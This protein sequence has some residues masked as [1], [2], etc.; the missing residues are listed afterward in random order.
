MARGGPIP[1][2]LA[3]AILAALAACTMGP[4][5]SRPDAP[6]SAGYKEMAGWKPAEPRD[7]ASGGPWWSIFDDPVLDE[8][9]R[10]IDV[11]NQTLKASEAAFRLASA[12]VREGE[13]G[14]Y[15]TVTGSGSAQR[16]GSPGVR[17]SAGGSG[18]IVANQFGATANA[19]WVPDI[20]GKIRRTVESDVA[21]AQ[22]SAADLA[23]ARLSAQATLAS[24]YFQLRISD[25]L[26]RVLDATIEAYQRSL[27]IARNQYTAG[28]AAQ[29]DLIT[30]RTQLEGAQAEEINLGVQRAALEHAIAVLTGQPPSD[31]TLAPAPLAAA[32]PVMPPGLPSS[33]LE[34]RPDIAAAERA[35][36]AANAQIGLAEAAYFPDLTLTGSFGFGSS[37]IGSLFS[38][39]NTAWTLGAALAGTIYDG[40]LRGAQVA[41]ARAAYEQNVANYR[42]T[43]LSGLQQVE[44]QIAAL[45]ILEQQ[46]EVQDRALLDAREAVR[47]TL[48][49][50]QAGTVAFT[51]VVVAQTTALGD[52]QAVLAIRQS[53]LVASVT[54]VEALG[55]GWDVSQLPAVGA[56]EQAGP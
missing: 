56:M 30:A 53:R 40:G 2:A 14:F 51:S 27:D 20:W 8:L 55:G 23:G 13:A 46:A 19:S 34:R 35:A 16:A 4:D 17:S 49:Q 38:V 15:P 9:E 41:A 3:A 44:D 10:R 54:L 36:A 42:Q 45:R 28:V 33:L 24:D 31:F 48:N 32:I 7:A 37:E 52:E 39:A 50:Y 6:A 12:I 11:S 43:V 21:N 26:K 5:Y 29:T 1:T 47:L 22:A 25:E 18:R